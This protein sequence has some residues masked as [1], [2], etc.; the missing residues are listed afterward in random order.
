M[1]KEMQIG[2]IFSFEDNDN[3]I[4]SVEDFDERT[5]EFFAATRNYLSNLFTNDKQIAEWRENNPNTDVNRFI[6]NVL[7]DTVFYQVIKRVTP[8]PIIEEYR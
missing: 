1:K 5:N 3:V 4:Q 6:G 7:K 2:F 8:G